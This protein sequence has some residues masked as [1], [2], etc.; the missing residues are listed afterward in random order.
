M[1]KKL[2]L[3]DVVLGRVDGRLEKFKEN[4]KV[5]WYDY[6]NRTFWEEKDPFVCKDQLSPNAEFLGYAYI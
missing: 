3:K 2:T 6:I 1:A 4:G 5:Y